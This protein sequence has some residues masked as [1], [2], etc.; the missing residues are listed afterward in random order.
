M[1]RTLRQA[2]LLVTWLASPLWLGLTLGCVSPPPPIEALDAEPLTLSDTEAL[3]FDQVVILF[4]ASGSME[5]RSHRFASTQ[6]LASSFVM[7]MPEGEYETAVVVFGGH[8]SQLLDFAPF[9]RDEVDSAVIDTDLLGGSTDIPAALAQVETL[10]TGRTGTTAIII[11]SDGVAARY[12][13]DLDPAQSLASA[14]KLVSR[15][16]RAI[17]IYTIQSGDAAEGTTTLQGLAGLTD[18]GAYRRH[19]DLSDEASLQALQRLVF[20]EEL[21]PAVSAPPERVFVD[22]DGDGVEDGADHCLDTPQMANVNEVGCWVLD[23]YTFGL[24][25]HEI[26]VSQYPALD[27]VAEVLKM[28]PTLR[29]RIDGHTD[30]TG[31]AEF[32]QTLS[33]RRAEAV[34]NYL[35][36]VGVDADRLETRGFGMDAPVA[37]N[38]TREGRAMNRRCQLT[39]LR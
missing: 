7:G 18:C 39:V 15:S 1:T 31:A 10:I 8:E 19:D 32:N 30:S 11:F 14:R 29:I 28:N 4:D 33:E 35:Q 26:L 23:S 13:R 9:D 16:D 5:A 3:R 12:G 20:V 22:H 38:N 36:D 17:C 24:Q 2:T 34:R 37:S 25:Q 6:N 21:R 27:Q